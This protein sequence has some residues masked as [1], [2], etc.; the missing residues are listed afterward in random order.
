MA[1]EA[2]EMRRKEQPGLMRS[3]V[4]RIH[5]VG[6]GGVGMSGIA[7]VLNNLGYKVSGSDAKSTETTRR[8]QAAGV[9]VFEGHAARNASGAQ[10]VV[11]SSAV[12]ASNPEVAWA[13][14]AGVPVVL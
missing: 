6:I 10:V 14:K 7:E 13:R 3:F 1:H 12:A 2:R 8:L 9:R 5:F 4:R 11:V